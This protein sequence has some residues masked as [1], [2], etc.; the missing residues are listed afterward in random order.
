[1]LRLPKRYFLKL[2]GLAIAERVAPPWLRARP[3]HA[4][5]KLILVTFGGGCRYQET[6]APEGLRNV[7]PL[8]A[9]KPQ[10]WFFA[11]CVNSGVLSHYNSTS[12]IVTGNKQRVD[13]FGFDRAASP[14]IFELYRKARRVGHLCQQ[15]FRHDGR[16]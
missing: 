8:A 15:E 11:N 3:S 14:T 10:G 5:R 7:P 1:M 16:Y 6:F 9:L 4:D 13:D 2:A 12:S